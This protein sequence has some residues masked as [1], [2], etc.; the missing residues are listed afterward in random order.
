[1]PYS[2]DFQVAHLF[3]LLSAPDSS[4]DSVSTFELL[5]SGLVKTLI[6]FLQGT[7]LATAEGSSSGSKQ[8]LLLSRL[9]EFAEVSC[10]HP[11]HCAV[12]PHALIITQ[13]RSDA[14]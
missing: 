4:A 12:S 6:D 13:Q 14:R 7:D 1:M 3:Q 11:T 10:V 5:S 9:L 8:E 2:S